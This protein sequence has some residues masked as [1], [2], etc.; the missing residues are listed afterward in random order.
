MGDFSWDEM[1]ELDLPATVDYII[2]QTNATQI[3]YV[4]HS[5]G[6]LIG[7]TGFSINQTL[8][9]KIKRF[10]ALAPIS[11]V[12]N[13]KGPIR[14]FVPFHGP[15]YTF[16]NLIGYEDVL[17]SSNIEEFFGRTVCSISP[18]FCEAVTFAVAGIDVLGYNKSRSD[19][20]YSHFPAGTSLRDLN[21]W[22]QSIQSGKTQY[23]DFGY[24]ENKQKYGTHKAP[25]YNIS[26]LSVPVALFSGTHDWMADPKDVD[27][28]RGKI[29]STI[30]Y[31]KTISRFDHLDF[32][33]GMTA[34]VEVYREIISQIKKAELGE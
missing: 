2:S 21:H 5:Q 27:I 17:P 3:Y 13:L 11:N 12:G 14:L 16:L 10:F 19:V 33:W 23:Y 28:L 18:L 29:N 25:I 4:G 20:Y 30:V 15:A 24:I 32:V 7:F 1:A 31:D 9:S 6:T 26:T 34:H 8:A 22:A